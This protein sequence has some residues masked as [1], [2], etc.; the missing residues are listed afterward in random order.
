MKPALELLVT[1]KVLLADW[2]VAWQEADEVC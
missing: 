1:E 2:I